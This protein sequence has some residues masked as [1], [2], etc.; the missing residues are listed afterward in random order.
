MPT[1]EY[2]CEKCKH[3]FSLVQSF[4]EREKAKV[5]CPKCKSEK[6]KQLISIFTAKTS[7][8]S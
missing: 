4:S 5:V 1:Y 3:E 6:V 2:A 7:R 8:K